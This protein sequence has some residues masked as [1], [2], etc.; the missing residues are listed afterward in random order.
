MENN[1]PTYY[2]HWIYLIMNVLL[3]TISGARFLEQESVFKP[4]YMHFSGLMAKAN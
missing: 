4:P 2:H 1:W 3:G